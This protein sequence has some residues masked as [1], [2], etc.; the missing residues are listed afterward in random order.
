MSKI[1]ALNSKHQS[2]VNKAI[3]CIS[4]YY[5]KN[6]YFTLYMEAYN[7][8]IKNSIDTSIIEKTKEI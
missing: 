7:Y 4:H 3:S 8:C 5:V 1:I 2:V 6:I